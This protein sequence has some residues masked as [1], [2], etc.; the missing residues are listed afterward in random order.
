MSQAAACNI[1]IKLNKSQL[2]QLL[3]VTVLHVKLPLSITNVLFVMNAKKTMPA[4]LQ[5]R[6]CHQTTGNE[7]S[8][9]Y[10]LV[11]LCAENVLIY[12]LAEVYAIHDSSVRQQKK[13][14]LA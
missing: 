4:E 8:K 5:C 7:T 1:I 10:M 12:V 3:R 14:Q 13:E 11:W 2:A 9:S 6:Q